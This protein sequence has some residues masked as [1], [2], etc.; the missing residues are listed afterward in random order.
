[1]HPRYRWSRSGPPL[2]LAVEPKERTHRREWKAKHQNLLVIA[3]KNRGFQCC[4]EDVED[5]SRLGTLGFTDMEA[6]S[7]PGKI[8]FTE[9]VSIKV[10]HRRIGPKE[11]Q[12]FE[13]FCCEQK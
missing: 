2:Y 7:D 12:D 6:L 9:T 5:E 11:V 3:A 8:N 4:L 1:M 13:K 10:L